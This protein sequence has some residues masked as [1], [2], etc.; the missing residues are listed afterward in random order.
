LI[1]IISTA[2]FR[3]ALCRQ[4]LL[5]SVEVYLIWRLGL[6]AGVR[7]AAIEELDILADPASGLANRVVGVQ[8]HLFIFDRAPEA[9]NEDVEFAIPAWPT[10]T[11]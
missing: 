4:L 11:I 1:S 8:V 6:Q 2:C 5:R 3:G 10:L 7:A 9:F